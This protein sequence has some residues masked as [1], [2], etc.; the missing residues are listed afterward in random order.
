MFTD[1]PQVS[2]RLETLHR[3]K[4]RLQQISDAAPT[5]PLPLYGHSHT[6]HHSIDSITCDKAKAMMGGASKPSIE[7]DSCVENGDMAWMIQSDVT[8]TQHR[9]GGQLSE[10]GS[11][12]TKV[13]S[14]GIA[15][16]Q[17]GIQREPASRPS[18]SHFTRASSSHQE[19][20][21]STCPRG[22]GNE[23]SSRP[24]TMP[25][26][27]HLPSTSGVE[28]PLLRLL[29]DSSRDHSWHGRIDGQQPSGS[30]PKRTR[31]T[32]FW[33]ARLMR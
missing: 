4:R 6:M 28:L 26:T 7:E 21:A 32:E 1:I 27:M 19:D 18:S 17:M 29:D 20:L 2:Q 22:G 15:S 31:G 14:K 16:F 3:R 10:P 30:S 9:M 23:V 11:G 5:S 24:W 33:D 13:K 12:G 25:P 8:Q